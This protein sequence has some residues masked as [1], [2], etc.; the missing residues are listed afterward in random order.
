[1]KNK[2]EYGASD[3]YID[4]IVSYAAAGLGTGEDQAYT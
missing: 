1:L 3:I 2:V 4:D